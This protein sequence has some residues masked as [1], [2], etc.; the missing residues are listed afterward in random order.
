MQSDDEASSSKFCVVECLRC[1]TYDEELSFFS[2][3]PISLALFVGG[4]VAPVIRIPTF[5]LLGVALGSQDK[6][7]LGLCKYNSTVFVQNNWV[8]C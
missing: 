3:A 4:V 7:G 2:S 8:I 1:R 6:E 5:P